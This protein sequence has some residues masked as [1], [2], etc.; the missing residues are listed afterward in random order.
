MLA[1]YYL[2]KY[3]EELQKNVRGISAEAL[4]VICNYSWPGNVR[5]LQNVIERAVLI[6]DYEK[7]GVSD[8]PESI[9]A[10]EPP[11]GLFV[12]EHFLNSSLNKCLTIDN[13]TRE[14]ILKYENAFTEQQIASML[15]ITRKCLWEKRKKWGISLENR[16]LRT[17]D[18][19][20]A[21][22]HE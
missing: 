7:I 13:Y 8:L 9:G 22:N 20:P 11:E 15:G 18:L 12:Q 14:F 4:A 3:A 19:Q 1:L 16:I 21:T 17:A 6:T 2:Q 10:P 5:E